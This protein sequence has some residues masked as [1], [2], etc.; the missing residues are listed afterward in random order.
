[1]QKSL[2][3]RAVLLTAMLATSTLSTAH[4][5]QIPVLSVT[6]TGTYNNNVSLLTNGAIPAEGTGWTNNTNVYWN[7]LTP[8]FT[9][10]F[11]SVYSVDDMLIQV[12]NNDSYRIDYSLNGSDWSSLYTIAASS[13]NIGWGMD[14]FNQ[15]EINFTP[16][17]A[18]YL[19][20]YATGG[21]NSYAI[22][23]VQAFGT[24]V[25][26]PTTLTLLGTGVLFGQ[27]FRKRRGSATC[28]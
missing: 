7:G 23:E 16:V 27:V 14:T 1:M 8:T 5:A 9:F 10:Q 13:G 18:K 15:T 3:A 6:G 4:A 25:P 12:D 2:S 26:E 21:D 20:V 22:S 11:N 24:P 19:R 17:N 28:D